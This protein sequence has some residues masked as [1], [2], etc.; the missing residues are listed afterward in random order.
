LR[1]LTSAERR[2]AHINKEALAII[3]RVKKYHQYLYGRK[4]F[5]YLSSEMSFD[6]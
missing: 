1:S 5:M 2:Y 4:F 3:F 6:T